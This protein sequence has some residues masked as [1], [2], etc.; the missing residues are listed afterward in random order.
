MVV[1]FHF[2]LNIIGFILMFTTY[3]DIVLCYKHGVK[4]LFK[5]FKI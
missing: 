4:K 3:I 5:I 1:S 2:C